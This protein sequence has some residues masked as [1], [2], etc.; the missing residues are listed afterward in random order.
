MK[1][2]RL[3]FK[4]EEVEFVAFGEANQLDDVGMID[5]SHDLN[6][7]E[8]VGSLRQSVQVPKK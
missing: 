2:V 8:N 3:T 1:R 4:N 5:T 7:F 6:L